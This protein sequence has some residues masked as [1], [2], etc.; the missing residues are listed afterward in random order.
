MKAELRRDG[1]SEDLL[2]AVSARVVE[3]GLERNLE[4][5]MRLKDKNFDFLR[6][7]LKRM[8]AEIDSDVVL[9]A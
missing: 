6:D 1:T 3:D 4:L 9:I 8:G 7:S 2:V 5:C